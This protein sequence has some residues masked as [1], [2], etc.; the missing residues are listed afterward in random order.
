MLT[1]TTV[2]KQCTQDSYTATRASCWVVHMSRQYPHC[3]SLDR[4]QQLCSPITRLQPSQ[5][6]LGTSVSETGL[7]CW[8]A[9][10]R[11][12]YTKEIC[13]VTLEKLFNRKNSCSPYI[14]M[15]LRDRLS[16]WIPW[17]TLLPW[18]YRVLLLQDSVPQKEELRDSGHITNLDAET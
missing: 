3:V 16:T 6:T 17:P 9:R 8:K 14:N 5:P 18:Y 7:S 1:F 12:F 15:V 4:H 2:D 10:N 11:R 13:W